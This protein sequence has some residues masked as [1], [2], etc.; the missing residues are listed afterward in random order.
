MFQGRLVVSQEN[1][2]FF[3]EMLS[4]IRVLKYDYILKKKI[5]IRNTPNKL[6]ISNLMP[7]RL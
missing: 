3:L 1:M 6:W 4:D 7:D 5:N 2:S